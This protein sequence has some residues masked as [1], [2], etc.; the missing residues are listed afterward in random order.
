M[1]CTFYR[2]L[3][4]ETGTSL[5]EED[6]VDLARELL[7]AG[8]APGNGDLR[9]PVDMIVT[10]DPSGGAPHSVAAWK[11]LP[12]GQAAVDVGPDTVTA[13]AQT[14][15]DAGT[16]VWNGPLGIYEVEAFAAGTRAVAQ[17]LAASDATSIVGGGDLAAALDS[18]GLASSV[19][20]ISTGGG[21]TLEF[22]EGRTL[23]GVAA[24][25]DR[26]PA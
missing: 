20:F 24:L 26:Q 10:T 16:V 19:S 4:E 9:L 6:Q 12:P 13:I 23:P 15:G 8:R 5:V 3:G 1:A 11:S 2:A 25:R 7:E 14:L 18:L 21:A 22:L 17:A